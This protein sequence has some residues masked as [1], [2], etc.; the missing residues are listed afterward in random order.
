MTK[1]NI[2]IFLK[3]KNLIQFL[4]FKNNHE[5][6][7]DKNFDDGNATN[8]TLSFYYRRNII[9]LYPVNV[10]YENFQQ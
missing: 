5:S 6:D 7:S 2:G 1:T 4:I 9:N 8:Y 3:V 10:G